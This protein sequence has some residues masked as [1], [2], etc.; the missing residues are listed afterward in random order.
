MAVIIAL[1]V[2][3]LVG[4]RRRP[5]ALEVAIRAD[6][7]LKLK[8]RLSTAWEF[9]ALHGD[10]ELADRLAVQAVKAGVPADPWLV[11]PLRVNRWGWLAPLAATALLLVSVIDLHPGAG[12]GASERSTSGWWARASAWGRS[13]ARC[14]HGRSVTSCHAAPG[15]PHSSSAWA[16]A[17]KA[18]RCPAAGPGAVA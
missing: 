13:G 4:W 3:L 12:A 10:N 6:V 9:V 15:R 11:F 1:G 2:A 14:R 8:Q 16:R 18:V 7:T 5:D 17:C